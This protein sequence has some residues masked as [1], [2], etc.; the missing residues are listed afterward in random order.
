MTAV[1]PAHFVQRLGATAILLLSLGIAS[2]SAFAQA[3]SC[4]SDNPL[5]SSGTLN[6]RIDNDM[7]GGVGQDRGYT[8]GFLVSWVSP[9]LIDYID[10]PCLPRLVR[11]LNRFLEVLQP[12][13]FDEQ[14]M[15]IGFGQMMYTP[16]DKTRSDLIAD[17][18][19]FAGALMLSFG[20]NARLADT[21]RTSQIRVGVVGPSSLA[22]QTQN[23]WHDIIGVDRFNGWG[24]QLRDEPVLQLIHERRTR[25][26]RQETAGGW[27]LDF[28]HHWG[29]SLGNFATYANA[30]AELRYGI[31]LPDDLGTAPLRPA[32]ENT[33]PVR[34]TAGG[35][36]NGH[37]FVALDARW[38]LHDIT[39]DG[40]TFQS[41][42]SVDKRPFVADIG[43]GLAFTHDHW[44]IAFARYY[45]TREFRGQ[46]EI[47]VYGTITVGRRF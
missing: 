5:R 14:N 42:H 6:L 28:T 43:Y 18:R 40:N 15:T 2:G 33:S 23:W 1:Q 39:L 41:S 20:Y 26:F 3:Q 19:P 7:F 37:L 46:Q 9:N 11:G 25:A 4:P 44:R 8:N 30:G 22:R 35:N 32:G 29:G 38:V 12:E 45:R 13:G 47:P 31:R 34:K 21:L 17:D 24:H 16:T 36:W 27:G 10:D